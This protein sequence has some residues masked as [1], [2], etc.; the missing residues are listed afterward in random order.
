[1]ERNALATVQG[2]AT[3][4]IEPDLKLLLDLPVEIGLRRRHADPASLNR[5]DQDDTRFHERVR[6]EYIR[7]ARQDPDRWV[8]IDATE[9]PDEVA[10]A[11]VEAVRRVLDIGH[12]S[13]RAQGR[14]SVTSTLPGTCS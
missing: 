6:Q 1:L 12:T 7:L 13:A 11:I 10:A 9:T 2:F 3:G 8:V 14:R 4:G 5:I